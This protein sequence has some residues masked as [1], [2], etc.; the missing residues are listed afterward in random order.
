MGELAL[1]PSSTVHNWLDNRHLGP[2][3]RIGGGV[4]GAIG[5]HALAIALLLS[6]SGGGAVQARPESGGLGVPLEP[7]RLI[8]ATV[9][10]DRSDG[11]MKLKQ[12]QA[13]PQPK[14]ADDAFSKSDLELGELA[15]GRPD[16]NS[17]TRS[18]GRALQVGRAHQGAGRE[19]PVRQA[20]E[21]NPAPGLTI[22]DATSADDLSASGPADP[23]ELDLDAFKPRQLLTEPVAVLS[24]VVLA[25]PLGALQPVRHVGV[26]VL[27]IDEDGKLRHIEVEDETLDP[28][29]ADVAMNAFRAASF[30]PGRVEGVAVK[31]RHRVEVV[32]E[33]TPLLFR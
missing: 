13:Y 7:A 26:L 28:L 15:V 1:P 9:V 30:A 20:G 5:L 6:G 17:A 23:A 16:S 27:F 19:G 31:A 14:A 12:V 11:S 25:T 29:L 33:N 3:L 18:L 2:P 8:E 24:E 22:P 4:A 32:F 10:T 21:L